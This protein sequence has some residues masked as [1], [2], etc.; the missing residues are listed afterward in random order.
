MITPAKVDNAQQRLHELERFAELGRL[1]AS[2]LHEISN[3]LTAAL[4]YLEQ[5]DNR[6]SANIR[7]VRRNILLLQRYVEAARQQVRREST[8]SSFYVRQQL[9]QVRRVLTPLAQRQGIRLHIE[10]AVN[11]KL[12]GDPV[13]FQQIMANLIINATNAYDGSVTLPA[14]KQIIVRLSSKQRW[15][16]VRVKDCGKGIIADQLPHVFEP[17]YTTKSQRGHGLGIGL[18]IVKQYVENDFYGSVTVTSSP[19][20]GTE[21]TAKL[22]LTPRYQKPV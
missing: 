6:Q 3:P 15:L 21:F 20:R 9:D 1:S 12:Y 8:L 19:I 4:L 17:F 5:Y 13:K 22:R 2:L 14:D 10:P 11:Y 18:A 7:Q 16:Y